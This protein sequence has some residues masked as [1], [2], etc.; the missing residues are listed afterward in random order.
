MVADTCRCWRVQT[1]RIRHDIRPFPAGMRPPSW[2]LVKVRTATWTDQVNDAGSR[3]RRSGTEEPFPEPLARLHNA[4]EQVHPF[5]DGYGRTGR[6][7]LNLILVRL[8]YPPG[9]RDDQDDGG[10]RE[11]R[12]WACRGSHLREISARS[13]LHD[14]PANRTLVRPASVSGLTIA[15]QDGSAPTSG[16]ENGQHGPSWLTVLV[17]NPVRLA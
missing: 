6:L 8:G 11:F 4:L 12:C 13:A 7:A 1:Q 3:L 17:V 9:P 16:A 10:S 2:T 14:R 15:L 5:L